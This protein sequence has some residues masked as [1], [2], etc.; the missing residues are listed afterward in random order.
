M[1]DGTG[2]GC[3]RTA[4]AGGVRPGARCILS[5]GG[6]TLG[7]EPETRVTRYGAK[8]EAT[9]GEGKRMSAPTKSR[10]REE[11]EPEL[12]RYRGELTGYSYRMLGSAFEAEDAVQETMIRA[13]RGLDQFDGRAS[14]RSWIYRI[15]TNVC[16]DALNGRKRRA[17]PMDFGGPG[18]PVLEALREPLPDDTWLEPM[19]DARVAPSGAD[20]AETAITRESIRLAFVAALQHLPPRQRVVLILREVLCWKAAEVAGLLGTSVASVNS[21]LQRARATLDER[22]IAAP[23]EAGSA[24]PGGSILTGSVP[25][26]HA[27]LLGKYVAAFESYDMTALVELLH[28]DVE[29][30][31]P[32]L[33]L[34]LHG[35]EDVVAW[36]VGPGAECEGSRLLP[37]SANGAPAFGQ[38]RLHADGVHRPWGLQVLR[39]EDGLITGISTF[40][41]PRLFT[42]FGLPAEL[43]AGPPPG[44]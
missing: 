2:A 3:D 17:V 12:E 11:L 41:N 18:E 21:A 27:E 40:L 37:T 15:A 16:I 39:I 19:P 1:R 9:R 22:G 26:E 4:A 29:Q 30:N 32:P 42:F 44:R 38:Y 24:D 20:P 35:R 7:A 5:V 10:S 34:W 6:G 36:M 25:Q 31:M 14:L 43:P 28:A 8:Y 33:E 13:W 23:G